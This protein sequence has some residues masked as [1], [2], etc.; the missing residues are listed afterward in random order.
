ME[1]TA[2]AVPKFSVG[3]KPDPQKVRQLKSALRRYVINPC[4]VSRDPCPICGLKPVACEGN[5]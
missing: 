1:G 3:Q 4:P 5:F 2:V